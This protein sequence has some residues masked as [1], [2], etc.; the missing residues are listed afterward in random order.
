MA[1]QFVVEPDDCGPAVVVGVG[2]DIKD[3]FPGNEDEGLSAG[4]LPIPVNTS[5]LKGKHIRQNFVS[6]FRKRT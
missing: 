2:V 1:S 3:V 5:S 6:S 4:L